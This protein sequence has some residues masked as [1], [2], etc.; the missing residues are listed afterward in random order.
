MPIDFSSLN[1]F[2]SLLPHLSK[3]IK[4]TNA[5]LKVYDIS[6]FLNLILITPNTIYFFYCHLLE[7]IHK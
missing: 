4:R 5:L 3:I 2:S 1:I 6:E 7:S